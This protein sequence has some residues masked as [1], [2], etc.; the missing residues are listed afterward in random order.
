[1]VTFIFYL[2]YVHIHYQQID[3]FLYL[4]KKYKKF[5]IVSHS[6]FFLFLFLVSSIPIL[7]ISLLYL[8]YNLGY[9]LINT[10]LINS[11]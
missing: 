9:L 10:K 1:M 2:I 7:S 6:F 11:L 5:K 4:I 3:S 8:L